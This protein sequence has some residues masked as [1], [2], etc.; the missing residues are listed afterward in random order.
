MWAG[1][2]SALLGGEWG[3]PGT[4]PP[5]SFQALT[6]LLSAISMV[7]RKP[8]SATFS[9]LPGFGFLPGTTPREKELGTAWNPLCASQNKALYPNHLLYF[10]NRPLRV[11]LQSNLSLRALKPSG[12]RQGGGRAAGKTPGLRPPTQVLPQKASPA[13]GS[14]LLRTS[15]G[16]QSLTSPGVSGWPQSEQPDLGRG[17]PP[18][19]M[20]ETSWSCR[21]RQ[22]PAR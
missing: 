13:A 14:R 5:L 7:R 6:A 4:E 17:G 2:D 22:V 19:C 3:V 15:S 1:G 10:H 18:L 21:A 9:K 8:P 16:R 12:E 11:D 20:A